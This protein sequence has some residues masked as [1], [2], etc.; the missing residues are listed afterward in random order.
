[1][2]KEG[3]D[4]GRLGDWQR[5][6]NQIKLNEGELAHLEVPRGQLES[7]LSRALEIHQEQA[8]RTAAKQELSKQ[9]RTTVNEGARV[10]TLL[11]QALKV[12]YG[13]EAEKLAEFGV[14][15]F[16]GG[17]RKVRTAP[18]GPV[19]PGTPTPPPIPTAEAP[20]DPHE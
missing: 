3:T 16:R 11:R 7:L 4:A 20:L 8:A 17:L 19:T 18:E 6:L 15:P 14:Q 12:H 1:M 5:L 10:A 2:S 13:V 9:F